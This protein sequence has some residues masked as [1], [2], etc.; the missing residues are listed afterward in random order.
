MS[1]VGGLGPEKSDRPKMSNSKEHFMRSKATLDLAA[2]GEMKE[3]V[4]ARRR[5]VV[6]FYTSPISK[7][8]S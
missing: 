2:H 1:K 8:L 6:S 4:D 3:I 7:D 5:S